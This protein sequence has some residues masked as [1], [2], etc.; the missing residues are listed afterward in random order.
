MK[1]TTF[2]P[3]FVKKNPQ[4]FAFS[5]SRAGRTCVTKMLQC[6][7][8]WRTFSAREEGLDDESVH[9]ALDNSVLF[10]HLN[11]Q[12]GPPLIPQAND[13]QQEVVVVGKKVL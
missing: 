12:R 4:N 3:S 5:V 6:S 2:H 10:P 13:D 11:W 8:I 7:S 9:V 1:I